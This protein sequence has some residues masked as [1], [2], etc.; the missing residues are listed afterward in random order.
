VKLLLHFLRQVVLQL[1]PR[2]RRLLLRRG[3][4]LHI[5]F[6]SVLVAMAAV[7]SLVAPAVVVKVLPNQRLRRLR[8]HRRVLHNRLCH[9]HHVRMAVR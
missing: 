2:V 6:A 1:R 5:P 8:S 9:A 4:Q 7:A 3:L